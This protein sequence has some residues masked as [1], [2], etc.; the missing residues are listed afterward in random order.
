MGS[1]FQHIPVR[2]LLRQAS[3]LVVVV[4][5]CSGCVPVAERPL[6]PVNLPAQFSAKGSV[7][8]DLNWWTAFGDP[9]LNSQTEAAL[10]DNFSLRISW[11]RVEE[12]RAVAAKAG[13]WSL[14]SL[15][16]EGAAVASRNHSAQTAR[17]SFLVGLA[18]SYE[19]DLWGRLQSSQTAALLDTRASEADYHTA[20]ISI[21]AEIATAW[22]QLVEARQ[23]M[24]LLNEQNKTNSK[25]L[26]LISAK[27]RAG[28]TGVADVLQQ[29]QLLE[30]TEGDMATLRAQTGLVEQRLA[31][32]R[33]D[34]PGTTADTTGVQL[35]ELPPLPD[36]GIPLDLLI[37][38]PDIAGSY[39]RLRSADYRTAA[40]VADRLPRISLSADLAT[41]GERASD[42]FN[43][44]LSTLAANL[45]GP[46]I[47]GGQRQAE[48]S[49]TQAVA[50]QKLLSYGQTILN[51]IGEVEAALVQEHE[52]L[53]LLDSLRRQAQLAAETIEHV[54]NRYRQGAEEYQR[55]L[56]A[57][58]SEQGLQR[59]ILTNK[60]LLIQN[61]ISLYRALSGPL[62]LSGAMTI[63]YPPGRNTFPGGTD[64]LTL[65]QNSRRW[66]R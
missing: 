45:F 66:N 3:I 5:C 40:A 49:R 18:A 54:S 43:N 12:A 51:A 24:Q 16:L 61:R 58:L 39:L 21:S 13:A 14:P 50:R 8:S 22:Y 4:L 63:S 1:F 31:I 33:G 48:V 42:L 20:A 26:E 36:T 32:L 38:R 41:S 62:P 53:A 15:G 17:N 65:S 6:A 57:L 10:S 29:R 25:V 19:L 2:S 23:Q 56:L 59:K 60:R 27:F 46:L 37:K 28:Q 11:E 7:A 64:A 35:P 52:Q 9:L 55:V 47:D 44:W 30:S 34:M